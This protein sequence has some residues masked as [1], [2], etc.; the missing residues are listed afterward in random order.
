MS[1]LIGRLALSLLGHLLIL[2][3]LHNTLYL[4]HASENLSY[5]NDFKSDPEANQA[6]FWDNLSDEQMIEKI[7]KAEKE[8]RVFIYPIPE[9]AHVRHQG[10]DLLPHFQSEFL[11]AK[12]LADLSGPVLAEGDPRKAILVTDPS[13]ANAFIIDHYYLRLYKGHCDKVTKHHLVPIIRNVIEN[14]PY[15]NRS[16]GYDHFFMAAY[17]NGA[18]CQLECATD[19]TNAILNRIRNVSFIGK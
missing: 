13:Q 7:V 1:R 4:S 11:Y 8:L 19:E 3:V 6:I 17:D 15:F 14:Y 12:Y 5:S 9:H 18:F 2:L 10:D 16:Y